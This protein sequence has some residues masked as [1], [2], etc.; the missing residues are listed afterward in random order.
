MKLCQQTVDI[1]AIKSSGE[2]GALLLESNLVKK[3]Q[4]LY[5]RVLRRS[6]RLVVLKKS[7]NKEGYETVQMEHLE[8][9]QPEEISDVLGLFR[10]NAQAKKFLNEKVDQFGLCPRLLGLE[11]GK[12]S[13]FSHQIRKCRGA[14]IGLDSPL[15]FN[16]RF[17]QAFHERKIKA[18]PFDGPILIEEKQD[19]HEE[20]NAFLVDQWCLIGKIEYN[21]ESYDF[22]REEFV[23]D[24]DS[25]KILLKYLLNSKNR[26]R[27]KKITK[28]DLKNIISSTLTDS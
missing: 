26:T 13:C 21:T 9:I 5:N 10:S 4:P 20:G 16:L 24:H 19:E 14:C 8:S 1:E 28:A 11:K 25:Y 22:R 12:G 15:Q 18:W 17:L 6:R 2:L 3:L 23:F 27:I 7:K